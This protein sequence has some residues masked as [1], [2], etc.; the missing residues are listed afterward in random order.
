MW[1]VW[2]I[3]KYTGMFLPLIINNPVFKTF[4]QKHLVKPLILE[5][6]HT[7]QIIGIN[8]WNLNNSLMLIWFQIRIYSSQLLTVFKFQDSSKK[9]QEVVCVKIKT[10][11]CNQ[12]GV[13]GTR[14][15]F[16]TI[17]RVIIH[18]F[19]VEIKPF[20][21]KAIALITFSKILLVYFR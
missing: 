1:I 18:W 12:R 10:H 11:T 5:Y 4:H 6:K 14:I 19:Q 7:L 3:I 21:W 15:Y 20:R 16:K 9:Y 2:I 13:W 17:S 8:K